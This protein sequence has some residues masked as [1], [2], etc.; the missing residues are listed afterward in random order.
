[1]MSSARFPQA[2]LHELFT[3]EGRLGDTKATE[4]L[5]SICIAYPSQLL[6]D[7]TCTN[8]STCLPTPSV[9]LMLPAPHHGIC[10]RPLSSCV[11]HEL[12]LR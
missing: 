10:S 7:M 11:C 9:K 8:T 1:M 3:G 5:A 6:T 12:R 4:P 2:N